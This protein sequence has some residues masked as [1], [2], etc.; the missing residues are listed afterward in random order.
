MKKNLKG[1][2]NR[3]LEASCSKR[4]LQN[5]LAYEPYAKKN[6]GSLEPFWGTPAKLAKK[7][8]KGRLGN[9]KHQREQKF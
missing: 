9:F 1:F 3:F 7:S 6:R 5:A 2:F 4:H 8:G